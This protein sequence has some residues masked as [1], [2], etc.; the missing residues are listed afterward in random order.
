MSIR[1]KSRYVVLDLGSSINPDDLFETTSMSFEV[2]RADNQERPYTRYSVKRAI[3]CKYERGK[4]Y[5]C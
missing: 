1:K 2:R 4:L 5:R 3:P